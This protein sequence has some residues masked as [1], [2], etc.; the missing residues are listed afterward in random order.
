M[1]VGLVIPGGSAVVHEP[2]KGPFDD[3]AP[4]DDL[5]ALLIGVVSGDFDVDADVAFP[6]DDLMG[7]RRCP[8]LRP[9]RWR[10]S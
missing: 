5:E 10:R 4:W 9:G 2:A 1:R 7:R 3:P 6:A 8:D